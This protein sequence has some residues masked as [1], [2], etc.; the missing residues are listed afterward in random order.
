MRSAGGGARR[1]LLLEPRGQVCPDWEEVQG[2]V[3][4]VG[5]RWGSPWGNAHSE[6]KR[7]PRGRVVS[8]IAFK[9]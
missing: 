4:I 2:A 3:S 5:V 9:E 8:T 1:A 6:E 7:E